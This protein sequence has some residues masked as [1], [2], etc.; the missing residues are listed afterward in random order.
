MLNEIL[1]TIGLLV[2]ISPVFI[3][4]VKL[5][6]AHLLNRELEQHRS[7]LET[8]RIEFE[9]SL[10]QVAFEHQTKFTSL[11]NERAEKTVEIWRALKHA[12]GECERFVHPLQMGGQETQDKLGEEAGEEIRELNQ[13][14]YKNTI[15]F[16]KPLAD[17]LVDFGK[18][19]NH[20]FSTAYRSY[21]G[22][23]DGCRNPYFGDE[24]GEP[25]E[26]GDSWEKLN[27]QIV[28]LLDELEQECRQLLGVETEFA[29]DEI[30]D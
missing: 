8:N 16:P 10:K 11:H 3:W 19:L 30:K 15:Y 21:K 9:A 20:I 5:F 1:S 17:R 4:A 29:T 7:R 2:L 6:A 13:L 22:A 25:S 28:P 27:D 26:F 24:P 23:R 18:D 12:G 14:I